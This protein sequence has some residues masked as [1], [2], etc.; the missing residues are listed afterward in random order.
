MSSGD[1]VY[2]ACSYAY[3]N[4]EAAKLLQPQSGSDVEKFRADTG[5]ILFERIED[6][7]IRFWGQKRWSK[8]V[9]I[10]ITGF[11]FFGIVMSYIENNIVLEALNVIMV[12]FILFPFSFI[13]YK[14][15]T[16]DLSE[17][18]VEE[19]PGDA[20]AGD[21]EVLTQNADI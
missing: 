6:L 8:T 14:L 4:E 17:P 1:L 2:A 3:G 18:E 16:M 11:M 10:W 21:K 13:M 9:L 7:N 20:S 5:K 15:Q 12:L 19:T